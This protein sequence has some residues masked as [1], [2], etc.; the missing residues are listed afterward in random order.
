MAGYFVGYNDVHCPKSSFDGWSK[1]WYFDD[2]LVGIKSP[3]GA[4]Y[5]HEFYKRL[6]NGNVGT[7]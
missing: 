7:K 2:T 3:E 4:V 1:F 6:P 5:W